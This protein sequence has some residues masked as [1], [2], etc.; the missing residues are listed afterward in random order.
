MSELDYNRIRKMSLT[1][2]CKLPTQVRNTFIN[3]LPPPLKQPLQTIIS[4]YG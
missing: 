4:I 1:Q 3:Q 2:L